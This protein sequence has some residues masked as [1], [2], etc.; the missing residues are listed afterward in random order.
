M[1]Q[2]VDL[3]EEGKELKKLLEAM[4]SDDWNRITPFKSWTIKFRS[5]N[6]LIKIFINYFGNILV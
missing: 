2:V 3:Y 6:Y 1:Q 5:N 4:S